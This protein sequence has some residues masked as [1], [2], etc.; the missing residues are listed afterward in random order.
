MGK[1]KK[2]QCF[3][4]LTYTVAFAI[5]ACLSFNIDTTNISVYTEKK[6]GSFGYKVLQFTSGT[7]K[8][9]L[10]T[11][12]HL[13]GTG[14]LS[15]AE[16]HQCFTPPAISLK[17]ETIPVKHFGLSMAASPTRATFT[18]CSPSLVHECHENSYL[19]SVCYEMT[20]DLKPSSFFKPAFQA[21][22]KKTV[23]LVFLFDGSESMTTEDFNKNKVFIVDVM[24][25]LKN[26]SIKFAAVQF[27]SKTRKVFDFNDYDA[28]DSFAK[29]QR[30]EHMKKLTNTHRALNY[31][32]INILENQTAGASP[33]ATKVVILIT[34][35]DPTDK[36]NQDIETYDAKNIIRFV[37]GVKN[38]QLEKLQA[39]ASEPRQ[40]NTFKIEDYSGLKG[41]LENFQIKIFQMEGT[42]VDRA[43]EMTNEMSQSGFSVAYNKRT[44]VLGAV[45]SNSWRGSLYEH[46]LETA[47]ENQ[48]TDPNMKNDSYMGYSVAVG[49]KNKVPLYFTG[50][51]RFDHEGQV[52][53]FTH[54]GNNWTVRDRINGTQIGSYFGAELCSV[55]INSDG[56]T[57]FL[58]VGAPQFY[59]PEEK[60]EGQIYI[61]SLTQEI[62]LQAEM[63][64]SVP[65]LGRF[66]TTISSLAD[67]NG[68]QLRDVAVGAPLEDNNRGAVY[69]YLGE[70][71]R[72]MRTTFSQRIP[73]QKIKPEL[74]LRFFGQSIDGNIDLG[75]DGLPDIVVGSHG[76]ATVLRS[77]PIFNVTAQLSFEPLEISTENINCVTYTEINLPMGNL[78][79]CF[80]KVQTTFS[81]P[82]EKSL[83]ISYTVEVD[84]N[85]LMHRG[86]LS[87][88]NRKARNLTLTKLLTG[89]TNCFN[90]LIYMPTCVKDTL[91]P[92]SVQ[93]N[94]SQVDDEKADAVLNVDN[95]RHAVVKVPFTKECRQND[96]CIAELEV[97]FNFMTSTLLVVDQDYFNVSVTL[98]NHGDDS[99]NT[100]LTLFYPPG[101]SFSM[102]T[103]TKQTRP[104]LH[105]CND[106]KEV[107]DKTTCGISLPVYRSRSSVTFKTVFRIISNDWND[108]MSMTIT[109]KSDNMNSASAS[110]TK[111]IPVQFQTDM[112]V[113]LT[114]TVNYL[115]FTP[116]DSAPKKLVTTY[117][118]NN[119]GFKAF[120]VNVSLV[121]PTK[122][123]YNFEMHKVQ[124][125]VQQNK[126]QCNI[127]M[128]V[129]SEYCSLEKYC[130]SIVC[131]SFTLDRQ[132]SVDF[133]LSGDVQFLDLKQHAGSIAFL[134]LYT[135]DRAE[136]KFKSS[137]H[138]DYDRQRYIQAS[139]KQNTQEKSAFSKGNEPA[140]Q[141]EVQ[142]EFIIP[143]NQLVITATGAGL[144]FLLLI[145]ITVILCKLGCFKRKTQEYYQQQNATSPQTA[146]LLEN[147]SAVT[148]TSASQSETD[149]KPD[150]PAEEKLVLDNGNADS[151]ISPDSTEKELELTEPISESTADCTD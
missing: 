103:L 130:K 105:S 11:A 138:V 80:Q 110:L 95:T 21:C 72:G 34:D 120:P 150:Q 89:N 8:G 121:L 29:L 9:V 1:M 20:Y 87:D 83:N 56:N 53:L 68:D 55:D 77:K 84:P 67:L 7:N 94:F 54:N 134:K 61:Y 43:G 59:L 5:S 81:K 100:S 143:P 44:L 31:T 149:G 116:E 47:A 19:H 24:N 119:L 27:S 125:L 79:V 102:M 141:S 15:N 60:R 148:P 39:I 104:T 49:E 57:D 98:S 18:V 128:D 46:H 86:F 70:Q 136:I 75:E 133:T 123:E 82:G 124:V 41:I 45:G 139:Q 114:D 35:G 140:K 135:G 147:N 32:L 42:D 69:I 50:A 85:R 88:S 99:Y 14:Q 117:K 145:I 111:H 6:T 144:G 91:S 58:L 122:L 65:S 63:T 28:G 126:T 76:T 23:N 25:S 48:I 112:A 64:V 36:N 132:S 137:L 51:P 73:G 90:H 13:S 4:L 12:P 131:D 52:I 101:L 151:S 146:S 109:G 127:I 96:T 3:F 108:T 129:K 74:N 78:T 97:D 38:V 92:V 62:N 40:N 106:Q 66:G 71:H 10:V 30:E 2:R 118:V 37:I 26:T 17:N 93:L 16:Q 142:V 33:D 113:T 107:I 115:N 22:T